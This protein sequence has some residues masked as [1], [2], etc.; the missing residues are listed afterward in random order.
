[1]EAVRIVRAVGSGPFRKG[2]SLTFDASVDDLTRVLTLV[3]P[4]A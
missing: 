2:E 1:M 3:R 4:A